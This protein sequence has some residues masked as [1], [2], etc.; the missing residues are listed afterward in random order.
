MVCIGLQR[1]VDV[2]RVAVVR[3]WCTRAGC[4]GVRLPSKDAFIFTRIK[5]SGYVFR[6]RVSRRGMVFFAKCFDSS[7]SL[8]S[9]RLAVADIFHVHVRAPAVQAGARQAQFQVIR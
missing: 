1:G 9:S 3:F 2:G 8:F 6:G 5:R 4:G 7:E